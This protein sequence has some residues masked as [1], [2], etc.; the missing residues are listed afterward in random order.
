MSAAKQYSEICNST[1][2]L[3]NVFD[4]LSKYDN[5]DAH[6]LGE[7]FLIDQF[8][9][10]KRNLAIPLSEYFE[11][12]D[13]LGDEQ[14]LE[15]LIEEYGYLDQRGI[16][17]AIDSY[18]E[19]QNGLP[20]ELINELR[21]ELQR[22]ERFDNAPTPVFLKTKP[23]R[24]QPAA[25][26][27][28]RPID[29][30]NFPEKIGRYIIQSFI[31]QGT[32]GHVFLA[33][34][35]DLQRQVAIKVPTPQAVANAGGTDA[36]I[37]EARALAKLDHPHIV[38]VYDFGTLDNG[39]FYVVSKY[40][41]GSDLRQLIKNGVSHQAAAR[42]VEKISLA[43]HDA[44]RNGTVH[45]DVKPANIL[46]DGQ[47]EPHLVDFGLALTDFRTE[48]NES[49]AGTPAYMSP[50]QARGENHRVDGRSD[51]Y[52]LG[53]V[54]Y[55]L[56]AGRRPYRS[57]SPNEI[58]QQ[59]KFGDVRPPR[60]FVDSIPRELERICLKAL[61]RR[62]SDRYP[63]AKDLGDELHAYLLEQSD[64]QTSTLATTVGPK[65]DSSSPDSNA[66]VK[67]PIVTP[68]TSSDSSS[69]KITIVPKGLRSFDHNDA[70]FFLNLVPGPR[71]RRG[72]PDTIRFWKHKIEE[73]DADQTFAVGLLYGPSGC[74][75]SS[76]VKAGLMP[77][78]GNSVCPIYVE[79]T[80]QGTESAI[81]N[82]LAKQF[83]DLASPGSLSDAIKALRTRS[84][85][86]TVIVIDQ[87][88]QWLHAWKNDEKAELIQALRQCDG[89]HV[90]II[91]M[92]RDDYWM[93]AT[94][95]MRELDIPVVEGH[96]SAP[97]D[98]FDLRHA[99]KVLI[100]YGQAFNALPEK[101]TELT[102]QN[103]QF[104]DKAIEGLAIDGK[105]ISVRLA[106]FAEMFKGR[107]WV[108]SSLEAVG[109]TQGVGIAFLDEVVGDKASR[110]LQ[111]YSKRATA[112]L[113][114]LLPGQGTDIKGNM[115]S[116]TEL[117]KA[118]GL[119]DRPREF[120]EVIDILD[121]RLRLI[122]PTES[123]SLDTPND[124]GEESFYQLT[125]DYLVP[126]MR[127]WLTRKQRSTM[128]GRARL[129]LAERA[130][131]WKEKQD[132]KLIPGLFEYVQF[133]ILTSKDDWN[134]SESAL[135]EK[136][137]QTNAVRFAVWVM[138]IGAVAF[139]VYQA[140][141]RFNANSLRNT[142]YA[143]EVSEL[144]GI[145]QSMDQYSNWVDAYLEDDLKDGRASEVGPDQM[146]ALLA[147][148]TRHP[149]YH[150]QLQHYLIESEP[151]EL[152][153][154]RENLKSSGDLQKITD[155]MW[156][157]A[158]DIDSTQ[159]KRPLNAA[160]ALAAFAPDDAR[161][162]QIADSVAKGLVKIR[163]TKLP[164]WTKVFRPVKAHLIQPLK[165][166][167]LESPDVTQQNMA[168]ELLADFA[169]ND[170]EFLCDLLVRSRPGQ[171]N[172]LFP[173]LEK[174]PEVAIERLGNYVETTTKK[175]RPEPQPIPQI[176]GNDLADKLER[177][178]GIC[179]HNM[180]VCLEVPPDDVFDL[181]DDMT[182][183]G[184]RVVRIRPYENKEKFVA[185]FWDRNESEFE[186]MTR[187][188]AEEISE[189]N[190]EKIERGFYPVDLSIE[191]VDDNHFYS[192]VWHKAPIAEAS[193][194]QLTLSVRQLEI[195]QHV[196]Q[197]T[198]EGYYPRAIDC[199]TGAE[200]RNDY[201]ILWAKPGDEKKVDR[202][203]FQLLSRLDYQSH[204]GRG[205]TPIDFCMVK[206]PDAD[207]IFEYDMAGFWYHLDPRKE[208][209]ERH[210]LTAEESLRAIREM[211]DKG[212]I[213]TGI[214]GL[215]PIENVRTIFGTTWY[216]PASLYSE[217]SEQSRRL[218][219]ALVAQYRLGDTSN[220]VKHLEH[221]EDP[222]VRS[223]VI[224]LLA[225]LRADP[226]LLLSIW[227]EEIELSAKRA[228]LMAIGEMNDRID[229]A[230]QQDI[231]EQCREIYQ[232][233]ADNGM[234]SAARWLLTKWEKQD[235]VR[236][237][238]Q[239]LSGNNAAED[240]NWY[241]TPS[242]INMV[243]LDHPDPFWIGTS[244]IE[245]QRSSRESMRWRVIDR[246]F[247][248]STIE[249]TNQL[250]NQF[251][252]EHPEIP[253]T[254][255]LFR[256]SDDGVA[257]GV[258]FYD[259]ANFC[260]WLSERDGIPEDQWCFVPNEQGRYLSGMKLADD[261]LHRTGYR[262][263][264]EAEWEYVCRAGTAAPTYFG[265]TTE[266][267][268]EY[269]W[270]AENSD[271]RSWP[272]A[273]KKPNDFGCFDMLG[274][275]GEHCMDFRPTY[276]AN[277]GLKPNPDREDRRHLLVENNEDRK[278]RG[279]CYQDRDAFIRIGFRDNQ[280]TQFSSSRN[281]FRIARTLP[282][283]E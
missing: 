31:G 207:Q 136:A 249:V 265:Y 205:Y 91:L 64:S 36:F 140:V 266:L 268:D 193:E 60:Q 237:V 124:K 116:A 275:V 250:Y 123:D 130:T 42:I 209:F 185:I 273:L 271:D 66:T 104:L 113:K 276:Q 118:S 263:P 96:N 260:N 119:T 202:W 142:L 156:T 102:D 9:R 125:H 1:S 63:T 109:G 267:F 253:R 148:S 76:M 101:L 4:F 213:L 219:T 196:R 164:D 246:R 170:P 279:G 217:V 197:K 231:I 134:K 195:V 93:A 23:V 95:L 127:R 159:F 133:R 92:V 25:T 46:I 77:L 85:Q 115:R 49:L 188:K 179:L 20:E 103:E 203:E 84:I 97:V 198:R 61:S 44:H 180:A 132:A 33:N 215:P 158:V 194:F 178:K 6:E 187:T 162:Q 12:S 254:S 270:Y 233:H 281:G 39:Q 165:S 138:L 114:A 214:D 278:L 98:L 175:L 112:I 131:I 50:E 161:W 55:E 71:D 227:D 262:M 225:D 192:M 139:T 238:D 70:E 56:L 240:K 32:F 183:M 224:H 255:K 126:A 199:V 204:T 65:V 176:S 264:T 256:T 236:Q 15:L 58:L 19:K 169:E 211:H 107:D 54:F 154:V 259:A 29:A 269:S 16:A 74:G 129:R 51:I 145:I 14:K 121:H 40:V 89:G 41:P 149:D 247:A 252:A 210:S 200:N 251:L 216:R 147:V 105:I 47:G 242:G 17:P 258:R 222:T 218:A 122:T 153:L 68:S 184:Y 2:E 10:W 67:Q 26:G 86:K 212:F 177:F 24:S 152:L 166:L 111:V 221:S 3:P 13:A 157:A 245:Q 27:T 208:S 35:P 182:P 283:K 81:A 223:F 82:Q 277:W 88:E 117:M 160:G 43:L 206:N 106:L 234:R 37:H 235:M 167:M 191:I 34:D 151:A 244:G 75:K 48:Q 53:I 230:T 150:S 146:R 274:N 38:P 90:Q 108:P 99:R 73:A 69:G 163:L 100:A 83:A 22:D 280:V 62:L 174:T 59:I 171:F 78:I 143:A 80:A 30:G 137:Y 57:D 79:A 128:S 190:T 282:D 220:L 232:T 5:I 189:A 239:S 173:V 72:L 7:I 87:F 257:I 243:I 248:M 141:M 229:L 28:T 120:K 261:Y 94:R 8:H 168:A 135:M 52:S 172:V 186:F 144:P 241:V 201:T 272:A 11:H 228:V 155:L 45:R 18:V 21:D 226:E 110:Q 181:I